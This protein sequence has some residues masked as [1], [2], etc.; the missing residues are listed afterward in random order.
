MGIEQQI[1]EDRPALGEVV[2]DAG[3][4]RRH[5]GHVQSERV[6]EGPPLE[7]PQ[8]HEGGDERRREGRRGAPVSPTG[9]RPS[10]ED[11]DRQRAPEEV[12]VVAE[13]DRQSAQEGAQEER[14]A[15]TAGDVARREEHAPDCQTRGRRVLPEGEAIEPQGRPQGR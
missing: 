2:P 9:G 6:S 11:D 12:Q 15:A 7:Q 8:R 14:A 10:S 3:A 1:G 4:E 13:V 5:G